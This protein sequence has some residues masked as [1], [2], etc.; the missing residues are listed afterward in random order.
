MPLSRHGIRV[1]GVP[2]EPPTTASVG[3]AGCET[4]TGRVGR[5]QYEEYID[6]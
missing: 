1:A 3:I 2:E 6:E 4:L 5:C